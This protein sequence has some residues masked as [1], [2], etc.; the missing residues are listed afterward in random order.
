LLQLSTTFGADYPNVTELAMGTIKVPYLGGGGQESRQC[1]RVKVIEA[2]ETW[3]AS[4]PSGKHDRS[5]TT[6]AC[7]TFTSPKSGQEAQ[8]AGRL[9]PAKPA[10]TAAVCDLI[11]NPTDNQQYVIKI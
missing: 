9:R 3:I 5:P 6:I 1:D 4:T 8:R 7:S 2:L 11:K 10:D